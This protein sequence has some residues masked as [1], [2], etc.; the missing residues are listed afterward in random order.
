[1]LIKTRLVQAARAAC[2]LSILLF[3]Y[4][5]PPPDAPQTVVDLLLSRNGSSEKRWNSFGQYLLRNHSD[6][7][8]VR[9]SVGSQ[10]PQEACRAKS[11]NGERC[12]D[13]CS[14]SIQATP[15]TAVGYPVTLVTSYYKIPSKHSV[16]EYMRRIEYFLLKI[17]SP[18]VV[19]T[20]NQTFYEAKRFRDYLARR[21]LL[22]PGSSTHEVHAFGKYSFGA[23]VWFGY[24]KTRSQGP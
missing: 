8:G 7:E 6:K 3:L 10:D 1:M 12:I 22:M 2:L 24:E 15:R 16:E 23:R 18:V 4:T 20:N 13:T 19:Y 5:M 17:L 21:A 11:I 14:H 9:A